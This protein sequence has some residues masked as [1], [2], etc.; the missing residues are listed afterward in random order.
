MARVGWLKTVEIVFL[1]ITVTSFV[2]MIYS[3]INWHPLYAVMIFVPFG[4]MT[5]GL[6]LILRAPKPVIPESAVREKMAD[7]IVPET[8]KNLDSGYCSRCGA[9]LNKDHICCGACRRIF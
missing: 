5:A 1:L 2:L 9:P 8:Q 6:I 3:I 7:P 4:F